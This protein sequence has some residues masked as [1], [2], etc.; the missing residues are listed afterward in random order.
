MS[1][2]DYPRPSWEDFYA[3]FSRRWKQGEHVFINGQTG[4]GKTELALRLMEIRTYSVFFVTKPRDPIFTSPFAKPYRKVNVFSPRST[5]RRLMLSA[6]RGSSTAGDV[7]NQ[8][9]IFSRAL[10]TIYAQGGWTVG[11]DETLWISNRLKLKQDLGA[12]AFMGRALNLS[13]VFAMQRPV[14]V[15]PVIPQSASHAFIGKT[16]RKDDRKTLAELYHD[17]QELY[18]GI[19]ALKGQHEFLYV[20]V[21]GKLPIQIVNTRAK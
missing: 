9:E 19:A 1:E 15:D 4:S 16:G 10:D 8:Y 14:N 13:Y 2:M 20:D 3:Q 18:R 12:A 17:P 21:Q 5:D 11:V 7:G 6:K